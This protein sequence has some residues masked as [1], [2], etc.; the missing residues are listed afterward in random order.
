AT[1]FLLQ[2]GRTNF[3]WKYGLSMMIKRTS[4]MRRGAVLPFFVMSF[5]MV[6]STL[7][8]PTGINASSSGSVIG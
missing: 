8:A 5:L 2:T 6:S 3:S 7:A 4:I 1:L